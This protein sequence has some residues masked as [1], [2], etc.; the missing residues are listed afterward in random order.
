[1]RTIV[2]LRTLA[3]TLTVV[4]GVPILAAPPAHAAARITVS[5]DR[6]GQDADVNYQTKLT[7][8]GRGFQNVKGGFGG[9]Y[10]MFGWVK[11][12]AGGSWRPSKG[13]QTGRDYHYIPD[14]EDAANNKGYLRYV[15]F[16]GGSTAS[17]A[18]AV[19]SANGSF[20]VTLTVPGPV[21][22][23]VDRSGKVAEVD[24]RRVQC[25]IITIGAHGLK[26]AANESFTPVDFTDVYGQAP[27]E[28]ESQDDAADD[29][30]GTTDDPSST[31]DSSD[32]TATDDPA[33]APT[34]RPAAAPRGPLKVAVD[35]AT[36]VEGRALAFSG[37]GFQPGEQVVA[38]LDDGVAAIGPMQAGASG[39]VAGVLQLPTDLGVGTHELRLTGA[40]SGKEIAE[41]FPVAAGAGAAEPA[42][43]TPTPAS[44]P[45]DNRAA[46]WIFLGVTGAVFLAALL[47]LALTHWRPRSSAP[48]EASA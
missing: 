20:S 48:R 36:A 10:V 44:D 32:P 22:Q 30:L 42:T 6:G 29:A 33:P 9:I 18:H 28:Q 2:L 17:E 3:A 13:G 15:A 4:L 19:L 5:N 45:D 35:R 7:L 41:R 16:P 34:N 21:F 25:G 12:P 8:D 46:G 27:T 23:S 39:E 37:K 14:S 31:D 1:M 11:D 38:I 43:A 47:G 24:C 26:N 40:A